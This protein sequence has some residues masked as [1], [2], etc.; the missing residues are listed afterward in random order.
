MIYYAK[1]KK[2]DT[3]SYFVD[4]PELSGCMSWAET[5]PQ[6]KKM[7]YDAL[8]CWLSERCK[9][10][11]PIPRPVRRRSKDYYPIEVTPQNIRKIKQITRQ[12]AS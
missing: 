6:A 8:N 12:C 3:Q 11:D 2:V 7:A 10:G 5:M 9:G 4:F 1:I